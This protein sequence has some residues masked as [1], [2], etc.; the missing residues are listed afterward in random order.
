MEIA[1]QC[2]IPVANT[3]VVRFGERTGLLVERFDRRYD[4]G[5]RAVRRLRTEA[6]KCNL[7]PGRVEHIV[8]HVETKLLGVDYAALPCGPKIEG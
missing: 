4:K 3:Q 8:T 6:V 2:G 7:D 5:T 1:R